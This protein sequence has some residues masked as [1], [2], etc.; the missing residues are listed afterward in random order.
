MTAV[1]VT[2]PAGGADPLVAEL[3]RRGY[4]AVAVPTV[5]TRPLTV[6]WPDLTKYDWI[7]VTSAA[8]VSTL[9]DASTFSGR[10]AA[11][12]RPTA[13][14]LRGRGFEVS[15]VPEQ[16]NGAALAQAISQ[17]NPSRVLLVRGSIA[18]DDLPALLRAR[19]AKV[20]EVVSYESVEG[21]DSSRE[22][23]A[24]A[25]VAAVVFASGSAVRGFLKLG[26]S[27][28]LPAITIGPRT[29]AVARE[30]GFTVLAEAA[31]QSA[32]ELATAVEKVI[33][34]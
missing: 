8:G 25:H 17:E 14:A 6:D 31:S 9:P 33:P 16:A 34:R 2:R 18:A 15:L 28:D 20:D 24:R 19:G 7:V 3:E 27:T 5:A 4:Q 21:P 32:D 13:Q 12:G 23:L 22:A 10:W 11:V 1:L 30:A 26:G 29:S